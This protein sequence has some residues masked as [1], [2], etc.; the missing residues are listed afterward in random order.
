MTVS[1]HYQ[2]AP[3]D[4][5][6]LPPGSHLACDS[7]DVWVTEDHQPVD[8]VLGPGDA[9]EPIGR[10]AVLVYALTPAQLHRAWA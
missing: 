5:L 7:G 3:R 8:T 10:G 1:T 6:R 2:L 9:F 4:I